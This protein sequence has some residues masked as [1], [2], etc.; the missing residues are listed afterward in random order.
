MEAIGIIPARYASSRLPGKPLIDLCG[1]S[2][3][4]RTYHGAK[5]SHVLKA[6]I[7]ATDDERIYAEVKRFG[8][9]VEMTS[10]THRSGTDRI[11]EVAAKRGFADDDVIVNIQGDQPLV[12]ASVI[13]R[14]VEPLLQ[15]PSLVMSTMSYRITDETVIN[16]PNAVKVVTDLN[17]MAL[18]FS[19]YPIPF[20]RDAAGV[21]PLVVPYYKHLGLYAY[22]KAFLLGYSGLRPS[23]LESNEQLEQLR[24]LENGYGI[25]VVESPHNSLE[26]DTKEDVERVRAV[27]KALGRGAE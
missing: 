17:G 5:A 21:D 15:D 22:R 13:D 4:E 18:Y 8:G 24:A 6:L 27:L 12:E 23:Y 14:L 16:N 9:E 20:V 26:I 2:M 11:A 7:V 25:K 19:R 3:I 10:S 1:K